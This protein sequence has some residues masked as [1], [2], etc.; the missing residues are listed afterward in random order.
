MEKSVWP[1]RRMGW[2]QGEFEIGEGN[3][4]TKEDEPTT[5]PSLDINMV[6]VIPGEFCVPLMKIAEL[7]ARVE[8]AVFERPPKLGEHMKPL[9]IKGHLD[10]VPV[11][12]MMVDGGTS[13]NIM[14][15]LL[16][17]KLSHQEKDLNRTNMSLSGFSGDLAEARGV[18][19]ELTMGSKTMPTAFFIVDVRGRYN[20]LLGRDWI[21]VNGCAPSM[22]HQC[23]V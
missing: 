18:S 2:N 8:R 1:E 17:E 7:C 5:Q 10:G 9:Y 6:F 22:P 14:P 16:F 3:D 20:M 15:V 19:K 11:G 12:R 13:V 23:I 21:H 4:T